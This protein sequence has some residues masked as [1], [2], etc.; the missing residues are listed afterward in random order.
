MLS[1]HINLSQNLMDLSNSKVLIFG[2][3][4]NDGGVGM[5][6]YFSTHA[7]S[8]TVVDGKSAIELQPSLSKLQHLDNVSYH[9]GPN[10]PEEEFLKHDIIVRNPAIQPGN[11]YIELARNAGKKIIMEMD[12]FI[13]NSPATHIGITGTRGKSTTTSLSHFMYQHLQSNSL[14]AGNIGR[15]AIRELPNVVPG[16]KVFL[17]ISSYQLD[18]M[19]VNGTSPQYSLITNIYKDH[20]NWH[21]DFDDYVDAKLSIFRYQ[22][23]DGVSILNIDNE[24]LQREHNQN[25]GRHISFS[26]KDNSAEY[27]Y[28]VD[29][30]VIYHSGDVFL[31]VPEVHLMGEH[32]Y[33]NILAAVALNDQLGNSVENILQGL[34]EYRPLAGRQ[35]VVRELDGVTYINNTTATSVEAVEAFL[36]SYTPQYSGKIIMIAGG[37]DKKLEYSKLEGQFDKHLK[38][39]VLLDGEASD[40]YADLAHVIPVYGKYSE[41]ADAVSKAREIANHGDLVVLCPG[42]SSFNMFKNEF[43]RGDQFNELVASL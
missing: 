19:R 20:L 14:L 2:L 11:K 12:Y 35:E 40:R 30:R 27:Y 32:N 28:D 23:S 31:T 10:H 7:R 43:D 34:S 29:D 33:Y 13:S 26:L 3:G 15:S 42:A 36:D 21:P 6:E 25:P 8:V 5:T 16:Q 18:Q 38:A 1:L 24:I 39:L 17:E 22:A 9:L 4:L 41:F 37:V